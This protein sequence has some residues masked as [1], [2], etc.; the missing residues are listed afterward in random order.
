[1]DLEIVVRD[2]YDAFYMARTRSNLVASLYEQAMGDGYPVEVAPYSTCNWTM[3]GL[4]VTRLQM[5]P[6]QVLADLGCGLGGIGLWLSRA[7]SVRLYGVDISP[8]AID[9][10]RSRSVH[11]NCRETADFRVGSFAS[12]SLPPGSVDCAVSIDSLGFAPDKDAA[13]SELARILRPGG[14]AVFTGTRRQDGPAPWFERAY[15][16]GFD[17]L[18]E[19]ERPDEPEIWERVLR[20]W[21]SH[22][23]ELRDAIGD[24]QTERMLYEA[25]ANIERVRS[26]RAVL[27]TIGRSKV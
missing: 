16:A 11:F 4:L 2:K 26:R 27:V 7:L 9:F 13:L 6:G 14:R 3:L 23:A 8:V 10:A 25:N 5:R 24:E 19:D 20:L 1:M 18:S 21:I 12:T 15:S 22:E 17:I